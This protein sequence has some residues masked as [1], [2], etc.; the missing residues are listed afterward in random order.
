MTTSNPV[1]DYGQADHFRRQFWF[2]RRLFFTIPAAI[3]LFPAGIPSFPAAIR[4]FPAGIPVFSGGNSGSPA[5]ILCN[6]GG[7]STLSGGN[8]AKVRE[9]FE[10]RQVSYSNSFEC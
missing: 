9:I 5:A 4:F 7:Y 3:R 1:N 8:S 10:P 2:V 6:S